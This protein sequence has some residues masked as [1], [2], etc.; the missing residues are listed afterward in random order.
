[1]NN[2]TH[3]HP[4]IPTS[5]SKIVLALEHGPALVVEVIEERFANGCIAHH[6]TKRSRWGGPT[7]IVRANILGL[8]HASQVAKWAT[9]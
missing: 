8:A 5:V 1:M 6:V 9:L 3:I 2:A 7:A 4:L